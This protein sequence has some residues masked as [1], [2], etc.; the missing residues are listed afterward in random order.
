MASG[1]LLLR[2]MLRLF[3][4]FACLS[5]LPSSFAAVLAI[6][7]GTDWTKASLMKPGLPFDVLLNR[8][9]KRKIHSSVG[10][11][12]ED[13]LFGSDALNIV[14]LNSPCRLTTLPLS[15]CYNP[16]HSVPP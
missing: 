11:N 15:S 1:R 14:S 2:I 8:D 7:Y 5:L 4:L 9:S 13:R 10:W 16:G 6:D 12:R 3:L